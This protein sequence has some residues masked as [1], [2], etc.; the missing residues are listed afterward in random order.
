MSDVIKWFDE[1]VVEGPE[2][3]Q[4]SIN[5]GWTEIQRT[6]TSPI[7]EA[8]PLVPETLLIAGGQ[9]LQVIG[10]NLR[11]AEGIPYA[12]A[13]ATDGSIA[14]VTAVYDAGK[15]AVTQKAREVALYVVFQTRAPTM[16]VEAGETL[17]KPR[18]VLGEATEDLI[19]WLKRKADELNEPLQ[20]ISW[21]YFIAVI[22]GT[23][24]AS[25]WL[26]KNPDTV[27]KLLPG[28]ALLSKAK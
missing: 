10:T 20:V 27:T 15:Q 2:A 1:V 14:L 8:L 26:W 11:T 25:Y 7:V 5:Y 18:I 9:E 4:E 19:E 3:W 13:R 22:G 17:Q 28:G 24:L 23:L 16:A 12:V 6:L 21:A